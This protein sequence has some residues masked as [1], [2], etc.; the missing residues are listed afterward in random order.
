MNY[1]GPPLPST[2]PKRHRIR[3]AFGIA[4]ALILAVIFTSIIAS[5]LAG[6]PKG[7]RSQT[8]ATPVYT[9]AAPVASTAPA[10]VT[11]PPAQAYVVFT[12]TGSAPSGATIMYGSNADNITPP[13]SLGVLGNGVALPFTATL[14]FD[15]AAMYYDIN[16]QLEGSGSI[17]ATITVKRAG[18]A[19][20]MVSHGSASGGYNIASA[21]AAPAST[22]GSSWTPEG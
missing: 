6:T 4:G 5:A 10:D 3:A 9:P 17:T 18:Y 22:D 16:A 12:V 7:T 8:P 2:P 20:L 13:G 11:P 1:T 15:P 19:D 14:K 21:Q